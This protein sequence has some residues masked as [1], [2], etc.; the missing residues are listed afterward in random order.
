MISTYSNSQVRHPGHISIVMPGT[1]ESSS[2]EWKSG[3]YDQKAGGK[4]HD[5]LGGKRLTNSNFFHNSPIQP[6]LHI[7]LTRSLSMLKV[8]MILW[9]YQVLDILYRQVQSCHTTT[10]TDA[11][12]Y[13]TEVHADTVMGCWNNEGSCKIEDFFPYRYNFFFPLYSLVSWVL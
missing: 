5:N 8:L 10:D 2:V 9:L 3:H 13:M 6:I 7:S 1:R 11:A 4:K 12:V